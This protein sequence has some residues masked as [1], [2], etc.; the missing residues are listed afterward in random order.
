MRTLVLGVCLVAMLATCA[1][2]TFLTDGWVRGASSVALNDDA[3]AV[4]VNPAGLGMYMGEAGY[5]FGTTV[6]G[7]NESDYTFAL[8]AGP[9]GFGYQRAFCWEAGEGGKLFPGDDALDTYT[10]SMGLGEPRKFSVGFDYRWFRPRFGAEAKTGTWDIG[11]VYRPTNWLSLAATAQ[12]LSE[13]DIFDDGN[14]LPITYTTGVAVRPIG[15]R[16]TLMADMSFPEEAEDEDDVTFMAGLETEPFDG[17]VLRGSFRS[18]PGGDERQEEMSAGLY[19]TALHTGAGGAFRSFEDAAEEPVTLW[20]SSNDQRMRTVAK[21]GGEIAEIRV[22]GPL[23][24]EGSRWSLFGTPRRGVRSLVRQIETA[25][26]SGTVNVVLL[27]IEPLGSGFLGAPSAL[28]QELRDAIVKAKRERGTK[29]VAYLNGEGGT[30]EY[31]LAS[32]CDRIVMP[33]VGGIGGLGQYLNVMRYTGTAEKLG[34][35]FD[36]LTAGAYKSSFHSIGAGPLTDEQRVEI[37]ALVDS[38]YEETVRAMAEGRGMSYAEMEALADGRIYLTHDAIAAG[39]ID[40]VGHYDDAKGIAAKLAGRDVPDDP[41]NVG[42]LNVADW[43]DKAYDWNYGPMIA[44]VGAYGNIHGGEGGHDPIQGG[45]SIGAE[46][47][48]A[49]LRSARKSDRVEAVILR[50]N[51]GGGDAVA[52]ALI[53]EEAAKLAEEKPLIVSMGNLAGSGG[54]YIAC[55]AEHIFADPLTLT[56]SI[57]VVFMKPVVSELF[58]KIDTTYETFS[59]GKYADAWSQTRHFTDEEWT[60]AEETMD[61]I[62][63]DF[64]EKVSDGRGIPM[65]E[66]RELAQGRVYTGTQALEIGLIDEL[67][68]LNDAIDHACEVVGTTRDEATLLIYRE[69]TSFVDVF[70]SHAT[71]ELALWKLLEFGPDSTADMV[72]MRTTI[73]PL[74][75]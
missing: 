20:L 59:R 29:F 37:Q 72:Q 46:T 13:P 64:M 27:R 16:L 65:D 52:S 50:I 69:E 7:E 38:N 54:Y 60:M 5:Y 21:F 44:V 2:A 56:G 23:S 34:I 62:Y 1:N 6:S 35:E 15:N 8:K 55:P 58:D 36:Y 26:E 14:P 66:V 48:V 63:E 71:A 9:V 30:A 18:A 75:Y 49:Q 3:T 70:M 12:N 11:A 32:A 57:G 4:L 45:S 68:G 74:E 24:D 39:L 53:W 17:F 22:K 41:E 19:F 47:L 51:S 33:R 67:G 25:S 42:T 43:D 40:D 28:V 73:T 10:F 31:Y 61:W